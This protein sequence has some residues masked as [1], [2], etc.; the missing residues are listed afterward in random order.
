MIKGGMLVSGAATLRCAVLDVSETG[1]RVLLLDSATAS[2]VCLLS[3][4]DGTIRAAQLCWQRDR[5]VGF[6]FLH[7]AELDERS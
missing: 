1:A 4:A 5:E 2:E 6:T 7:N 3:L